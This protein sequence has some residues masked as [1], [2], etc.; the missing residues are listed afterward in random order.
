MNTYVSFTQIH[1]LICIFFC[2]LCIF[3]NHFKVHCRH[4]VTSPLIFQLLCPKSKDSLI[5][6]LQYIIAQYVVIPKEFNIEAIKSNIQSIWTSSII[7]KTYLRALKKKKSNIKSRI[8]HGSQ[9]S[10]LYI[11]LR[12]E[13]TP[14]LFWPLMTLTFL[15][16]PGQLSCV[17]CSQHSNQR[18]Y[19]KAS[20]DHVTPLLKTLR[21]LRDLE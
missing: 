3:L 8:T 21:Q 9:L 12:L 10:G 13:Q 15:K 11:L 17:L 2:S 5:M 7:S 1:K 19:F 18:N 4:H 20:L 6:E 14:N 16:R